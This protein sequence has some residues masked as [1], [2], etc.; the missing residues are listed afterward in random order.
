[1]DSM[2]FDHSV[3]QFIGIYNNVVPKNFCKTVRNIADSSNFIETRSTPIIK[4]KQI[5]LDAF[6]PHVVNELYEN[7]LV[8]CLLNYCNYYPY[9]GTCNFVSSSALLQVTEPLG[10]GYHMFHCE[11]AEWNTNNRM[12]VW[13]VYLNDVEG[14]ETEFI[15]QGTKINPV[16]GRIVIWPGS[17]T[18]LHRGNPP[19]NTK[20]ILTGWYQ[21]INGIRSYNVSELL[22]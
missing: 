19:K 2:Q 1:M 4:D 20:Y 13:M 10:G 5:S 16:E 8:P 12:L 17:F 14:G 11:N 3:D 6:Y 9:L 22:R 15:Y 21:N 18:H 7:A